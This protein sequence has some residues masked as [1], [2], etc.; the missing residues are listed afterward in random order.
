MFNKK[1]E[2]WT[3][4]PL[5][6]SRIPVLTYTNKFTNKFT[7]TKQLSKPKL[8]KLLQLSLCGLYTLGFI[9]GVYSFDTLKEHNYIKPYLY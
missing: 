8:T 7:S 5:L 6:I 4:P 9:I 3:I 2:I 1:L